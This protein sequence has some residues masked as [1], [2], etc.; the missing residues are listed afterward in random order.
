MSGKVRT[1]YEDFGR[2]THRKLKD[3]GLL[4]A[5][6][7]SPE[8][9]SAAPSLRPLPPL[10]EQPPTDAL[11]RCR[12]PG[13]PSPCTLAFRASSAQIAE[14]VTTHT[15]A[16][17]HGVRGAPPRLRERS[18]SGSHLRLRRGDPAPRQPLRRSRRSN[19]ERSEG[20]GDRD[21]LRH[22]RP[23][24]RQRRRP[25]PEQ[26]DLDRRGIDPSGPGRLVRD[27]PQDRQ[28]EGA[29]DDDPPRGR[30]RQ[31]ALLHRE[32]GRANAS[33]TSQP[34]D[35]AP[36]HPLLGLRRRGPFDRDPN[37]PVEGDLSAHLAVSERDR[38]GPQEGVAPGRDRQ[39]ACE[40]VPVPLCRSSAPRPVRRADPRGRS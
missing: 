3:R 25:A 20:Y 35:D 12:P 17:P 15:E 36:R 10:S 38:R 28:R 29:D 30:D 26:R 31:A 5:S 7:G 1:L 11:L 8:G 21:C 39:R 16:D 34:W 27:D 2:L 6:K 22:P 13:W 37:E 23:S 40:P 4:P 14:I 18:R 9:A 32:R 24:D 19:V 33:P